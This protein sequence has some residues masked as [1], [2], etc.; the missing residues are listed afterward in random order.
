M[1]SRCSF[2][3][4]AFASVAFSRNGSA[5]LYDAGRSPPVLVLSAL[6]GNRFECSRQSS[7]QSRRG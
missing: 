6:L 7:K 3:P 2:P 1:H 5:G 4:Q